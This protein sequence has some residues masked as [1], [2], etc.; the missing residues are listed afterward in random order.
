MAKHIS[1]IW[2]Q[3]A[4]IWMTCSMRRLDSDWISQRL[5]HGKVQLEC[6]IHTGTIVLVPTDKLVKMLKN[7]RLGVLVRVSW[8]QSQLADDQTI[9]SKNDVNPAKVDACF[10]SRSFSQLVC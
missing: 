4:W 1:H 3:K 2:T 9:L 5:A 6:I 7:W 10:D 8:N